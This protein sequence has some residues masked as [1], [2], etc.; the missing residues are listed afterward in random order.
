MG[1]IGIDADTRE[2]RL[3]KGSPYKLHL[4]LRDAGGAW[5]DLTAR[6]FRFTIFRGSNLLY[7]D[8]DGANLTIGS[9]ETGSYAE[10]DLDGDVSRIDLLNGAT[11][12]IAELVEG[13]PAPMFQGP[14]YVPASSGDDDGGDGDGPV[15]EI[16]W[17]PADQ[18]LIADLQGAPGKPA[19]VVA[20]VE[21]DP[22]G[23]ASPSVDDFRAW[24]RAPAEDAAEASAEQ[25]ALAL[26]ATNAASAAADLANAKAA[27]AASKA[28][29]AD[30][31]A[32]NADAKAALAVA[33]TSA[34]ADQTALALAA[35]NAAN[36]AAVYAN[37]QAA[38]ANA[39]TG[40][41]NAATA[42]ANAA[43]ALAN[44]ATAAATASGAGADTARAAAQAVVD[45]W[46]AILPSA[47]AVHA[48][49]LSAA[50]SA[51][52]LG[53]LATR[54]SFV[55]GAM[56]EGGETII[57]GWVQ[58]GSG[59]LG[60]G[61]ILTASNT[62][63]V[64]GPDGTKLASM[65]DIPII[66]AVVGNLK[67]VTDGITETGEAVILGLMHK[68]SGALALAL[69]M[70]A[71]AWELRGPSN[72]RLATM[73]DIPPLPT[74]AVI[75]RTVE[76][77][78]FGLGVPGQW[79]ALA[80][81]SGGETRVADL[82]NERA[83]DVLLI[84][85]PPNR[86]SIIVLQPSQKVGSPNHIEWEFTYTSGLKSWQFSN[87]YLSTRNAL[88]FETTRLN[89]FMTAGASGLVMNESIYATGPYAGHPYADGTATGGGYT[90]KS[91]HG[92]VQGIPFAPRQSTIAPLI[93]QDGGEV[94]ES[95]AIR[96]RCYEFE[97]DV[98]TNWY[99]PRTPALDPAVAPSYALTLERWTID[100]HGMQEEIYVYFRED[101]IGTL[102]IEQWTTQEIFT[103]ELIDGIALDH[104][105]TTEVP[106]P[107]FT[108]PT[109]VPDNLSGY[110]IRT[111]NAARRVRFSNDAGQS[112][113]INMGM[114]EIFAPNTFGRGPLQPPLKQ[115]L[116]TRATV[117][118]YH[119]LYNEVSG[120][121]TYNPALINGETA[122]Y[123]P[124][125]T[126]VHIVNRTKFTG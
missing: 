15:D 38:A 30:A 36:A 84:S 16:V 107:W 102:N 122:Y 23:P 10:L 113:V 121:A 103:H 27:L 105:G 24:L 8:S 4:R 33:Q 109:D 45:A 68:G 12:G 110:Q 82:Y 2:L 106:F 35:T 1:L 80:I 72:T 108:L 115:D 66:P 86:G 32:A 47:A 22:D 21:A 50:A 59:V 71:G 20:Y 77:G 6:L 120:P 114:V 13:G 112:A 53:N 18:V 44:A 92:N 61:L 46:S 99:R 69:V 19:N 111:K 70:V 58:K 60:L 83:R 97:I 28:A 100:R 48:D 56:T 31:A 55:V 79:D 26:A 90:G 29:L 3:P 64:R 40:L 51:A 62:W 119:K 116:W 43:I 98:L 42:N 124:A 34:S 91:A 49:A 39:S 14:V 101:Y 7:P 74:Y 123:Y 88:S 81:G 94:A 5:V 25:T 17:S 87:T 89:A 37:A 75:R 85:V 118:S 52:L 126:I 117:G 125:G 57:A 54:F 73:S 96:P 65:N 104:A 9:D 76:E 11:W 67:I 78:L 63:E 93:Y 41:A 95:A